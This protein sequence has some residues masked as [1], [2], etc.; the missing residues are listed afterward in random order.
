M[1]E[2]V[3]LGLVKIPVKDI[4]VIKGEGNYSNIFTQDGK[5]ISLPLDY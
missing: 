2:Y 5:R 4:L 3:V 1:V